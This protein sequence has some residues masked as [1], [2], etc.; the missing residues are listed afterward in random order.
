M[1]GQNYARTHPGVA[2]FAAEVS[3]GRA[4]GVINNSGQVDPL[5]ANALQ[6]FFLTKNAN[7]QA[8]MTHGDRRRQACAA[9]PR[10]RS[11]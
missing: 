1:G 3:I 7:V 8:I 11:A 2:T 10:T 9:T 6:K 4:A 5:L